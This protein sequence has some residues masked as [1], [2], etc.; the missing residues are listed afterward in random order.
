MQSR[1][2]LPTE[3]QKPPS[4]LLIRGRKVGLLAACIPFFLGLCGLVGWACGNL[5]LTS[6]QPDLVPIN[7]LTAICM[8]LSGVAM[9]TLFCASSF[10]S[11][12]RA[13]RMVRLLAVFILAMGFI[14]L[15][16]FYTPWEIP[17]DR[18]LF[19]DKLADVPFGPNHMAPNTA[20]AFMLLGGALFTVARGDAIGRSL[21]QGLGILLAAYAFFCLL[22]YLFHFV[23]LY[24]VNTHIPMAVPTILGFLSASVAALC[25]DPRSGPMALLFSESTG[26]FMVR[27]LLPVVIFVPTLAAWLRLQ[28]RPDAYLNLIAGITQLTLANVSIASAAVYFA[29]KGL[30]G[31]DRKR[32]RAEEEVLRL[33]ASLRDRTAQL[34]TAN[35]GLE[36]FSASVS[37]DLR[38]P[39]RHVNGYVEMLSRGLEGKLEGK[40]AHYLEV[41]V[42]AVKR[43]DALIDDLLRFAKVERSEL[44]MASV[45]MDKLVRETIERLQPDTADRKVEW[46]V[47]KLPETEADHALVAQVLANLI[48][49]ALKYS[50]KRA[51]AKVEIGFVGGAYFV[52]DN[53]V[54]FDMARAANLFG[55][56][57]R[58]HKDSEYEGTGIGLANVRS[59]VQKHGGKVWA[60]SEPGRGATFYFSLRLHASKGT[61]R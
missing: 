48:S 23:S 46:R 25:L 50:R 9:L 47:E 33:N 56:F 19:R 43:M 5:Y 26:G 28:F 15:M 22:G 59:I 8:I 57:Q 24:R 11:P 55:V 49:N 60:E 61:G 31:S 58:L 17:L 7:P 54:G 40:S 21:S 52:R 16:G 6:I 36:A 53:G 44:R 10:A 20:C 38:A 3:G 14:R 34:E 1:N 32:R 39:L 13:R 51:D 35:Q 27:R 4:Q 45:D 42:A 2:M 29:S 18:I 37:H 12:A 41:I 30:D